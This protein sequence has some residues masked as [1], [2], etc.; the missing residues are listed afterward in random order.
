MVTGAQGQLGDA[1]VRTFADRELLAHT[2]STLDITDPEAVRRAV[3]DAQPDTIINCAAFNDV[4]GAEDTPEAAFAT[5]AFAVRSLARA[6]AAGGAR[7]MHY[8]TDFVFAGDK[9]SLP[10]QETAT[11]A[12]Q[13]AYAAS[14]LTGE[15]FALAAPGGY[16]LRVESL[17]GVPAGWRGRRG[18]L[19]KIVDGIEAG[20]EVP[21]FVDRIVTPSYVED[22][23]AATK[24]LLDTD[25]APGVYHCVN[26]GPATWFDVAETVARELGI[27]PNLKAVRVADVKLKA[28]RPQYCAL[29]N[30]KLAA[31]GF[32]MP[33][34]QDALR[35]WLAGRHQPAA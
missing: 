33:H 30:S 9:E 6:A 3:A 29:D 19:E 12:P 20:R 10:H 32:P 34:W 1:I 28:A 27:V 26:S 5:N 18:T 25:A 4:D 8:G 23:A 13:S 17:F 21:V 22:V 2:R 35:R 14:K 7:L 15:W 24:H 31:A 11:P 16:V